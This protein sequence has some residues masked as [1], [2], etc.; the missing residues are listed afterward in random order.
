MARASSRDYDDD[1]NELPQSWLVPASGSVRGTNS[2]AEREAVAEAP[3]DLAKLRWE[4]D[5]WSKPAPESAIGQDASG[6]AQ[7]EI[8]RSRMP[9]R[10]GL[11]EDWRARISPH[12]LGSA[13]LAAYQDATVRQFEAAKRERPYVPVAEPEET[14]EFDTEALKPYL[15]GSPRLP[16]NYLADIAAAVERYHEAEEALERQ[17]PPP[18]PKADGPQGAKVRLLVEDSMLTACEIDP[19]WAGQRTAAQIMNEFSKTLVYLREKEETAKTKEP[20]GPEA[21]RKAALDELED[22]ANEGVAALL[23][24]L[25]E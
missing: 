15:M 4:L 17:G 16:E 9:L 22:L 18:P 7:M 5:L 20:V 12:A 8:A 6:Q 3:V 14:P 24:M 21:E 1:E 25:N 10:L 23:A 11:A 2:E 19:D 13:V